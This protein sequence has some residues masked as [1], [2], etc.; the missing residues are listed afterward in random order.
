MKKALLFSWVAFWLGLAVMAPAIGFVHFGL[1][2]ED[3]IPASSVLVFVGFCP[4][5]RLLRGAM[6]EVAR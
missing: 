3:V 6:K 5:S 1:R 4:P 2:G